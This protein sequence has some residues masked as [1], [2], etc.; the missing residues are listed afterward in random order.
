MRHEANE[1]QEV[2]ALTLGNEKKAPPM[3]ESRWID[4]VLIFAMSALA[5]Y[6]AGQGVNQPLAGW[7]LIGVLSFGTATSFLLSRLLKNTPFVVLDAWI[8]L[9]AAL[10]AFF[11]QSSL[12]LILPE[13]SFSPEIWTCGLLCWMLALGSFGT[14]RDGPLLFQAVPGLALFGLVGVYDTFSEAPF[15]FFGYLLCLAVLF[16]RAHARAMLVQAYRS[17]FSRIEE[18]VSLSEDN[19]E[20]DAMLNAM[21]RGPWRWMAGP[22]WALASAAAVVLISLVGAPIIKSSV[23]DFSGI[24]QVNLPHQ[25]RAAKNQNDANTQTLV[26]VGTGPRSLSSTIVMLAKLDHPRY[27]RSTTY[28]TFENNNWVPEAAL[29]PT[30]VTASRDALL[31]SI[32]KPR[33][34]AFS[35][36]TVQ[37]EGHQL[38]LPAEV[39][40]VAS[41]LG[42]TSSPDGTYSLNGL[43]TRGMEFV[44][45]AIEPGIQPGDPSNP[46][47][48]AS[49][50][51]NEATD[52]TPKIVSLVH[53]I[54]AG[55]ATDWEKANAIMEE[56]GRRC[57]Y[58]LKA[59]AVPADGNAVESFLFDQQQGYCDLFAT[60]MVVMARTAGITARY[61]VGYLESKEHPGYLV[62][63]ESDAHAWAELYFRGVGWVVFDA[64]G[65][66]QD[67]TP[68]GINRTGTPDWRAIAI[69]AVV[70]VG[71]GLAGY[72]VY[73]ARQRLSPP[74]KAVVTRKRLGKAYATFSE[75]LGRIAK[76][77]RLPQTTPDAWMEGVLPSLGSLA[78]PAQELNQR[79]VAALYSPKALSDQDLDQLERDVKAFVRL[80]PAK[81]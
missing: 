17:G 53:Q 3:R 43:T 41:S 4:S 62:V 10:V 55:K 58:N 47:G 44:G 45:E 14:W 48:L 73:F 18:G 79:F 56:I 76:L 32:L 64:T 25:M 20:Q 22:E 13:D 42:R 80:N 33:R 54:T 39:V 12:N 78:G 29:E 46:Y 9:G 37:P 81:P 63:R 49:N 30:M 61:A 34:F 6:T 69:G 38:A 70:V 67:V 51:S 57:K 77:R 36:V 1:G 26:R 31:K 21:R 65:L 19:S 40:N 74:P 8:Y 27:L 60:A 23:K 71:L 72:G 16:G 75:R 66:A 35:V 24:V 52:T 11:F 28:L 50:K 68:G 7:I 2:S 59:Q 5:L 15:F